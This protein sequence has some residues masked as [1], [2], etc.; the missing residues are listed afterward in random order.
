MASCWVAA[1]A[2]SI[3]GAVV[4]RRPV[5]PTSL[6]GAGFDYEKVGVPAGWPHL[7]GF[8]AHWDKNTN[9]AAA[10]DQWFL[11]L[12]PRA[13]PFLFNRGGYLTLSFVP[14]LA[15]MLLGLLAGGLVGGAS[16][17]LLD[18]LLY[19]DIRPLRP[20]AETNPFLGMIGI[21]QLQTLCEVAGVAGLLLVAIWLYAERRAA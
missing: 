3:S 2:I 15:T 17:P 10:F 4:R 18:G 13:K 1:R 8:A 5:G 9:F 19:T 14:S 11:N 6:P 20:M 12:L 21:E 16:H 7:Q